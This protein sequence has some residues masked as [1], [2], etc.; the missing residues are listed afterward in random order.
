MIDWEFFLMI[1]VQQNLPFLSSF[2]VRKVEAE[3]SP[4]RF[5]RPQDPAGAGRQVQHVSA[6]L[7]SVLQGTCKG[8][9]DCANFSIF[10]SDQTQL[11][12]EQKHQPQF[13]APLAQIVNSGSLDQSKRAFPLEI[14]VSGFSLVMRTIPS[15]SNGC[16]CHQ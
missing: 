12:R 9:V 6:V 1:C 16:F 11:K 10:S 8:G 2:L 14:V 13:C 7:V 15:L 4:V 5:V 3:L